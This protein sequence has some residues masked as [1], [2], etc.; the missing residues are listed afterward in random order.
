MN[1]REYLDILHVAERLKDTPR[2]CTT[3]NRRTESVAEHSWRISLMALLLR[4]EFKDIDID[5]VI[6][7]CI[8]HDLGECFT[9]DIPTF[10]KT[11]DDREVEDSLLNRWVQ[12]LPEE[13]SNDFSELYKE[14]DAQETKEA[15]LYKALD[16]LE[17]LIQHNESPI[18]TWSENE[19]KLNK[20]YAFDTVNF[21]EWLTELRKV[22][23]EDTLKKIDESVQ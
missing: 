23:L 5:K 3:T 20:T 9:G 15:K 4:H 18:D 17:A 14:M 12:S 8:I 6:D 2:H 1:A 10:M 11:D 21:S 16:K 19:Y 7:M 13:I 22:I